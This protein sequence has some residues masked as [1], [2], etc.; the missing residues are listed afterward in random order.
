MVGFVYLRYYDFYLMRKFVIARR[1]AVK[2][3]DDTIKPSGLLCVVCTL[4]HVMINDL[5]GRI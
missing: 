1:D 3:L 4:L 2:I 5:G